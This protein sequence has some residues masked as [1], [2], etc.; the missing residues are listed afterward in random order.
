MHQI[1]P[2]KRWRRLITGVGLLLSLAGLLVG[3]NTVARSQA[4]M[5]E[6]L[7][8]EIRPNDSKLFGYRREEPTGAR[9]HEAQV[10]RM[11]AQRRG[12]PGAGPRDRGGV[13]SYRLLRANTQRALLSTGFCRDGYLELDRRIS[14]NVLWLRGECRDGAT[15]ED[16]ERFGDVTT[17]DLTPE[18]E[19]KR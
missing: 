7:D 11:R 9:A 1:K 16:R 4:G 6:S 2:I 19:P 8:V 5:L 13:R 15:D 14:I 17:L 10:Q 12:G 3:C 18:T